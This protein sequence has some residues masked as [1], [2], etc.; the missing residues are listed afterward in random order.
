[1]AHLIT[2]VQREDDGEDASGRVPPVALQPAVKDVLD[3]GWMVYQDLQGED[4]A[5]SEMA[6]KGHQAPIRSHTLLYPRG[7]S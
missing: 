6:G 7:Q 2:D 3:E 5:L 4:T 1:M